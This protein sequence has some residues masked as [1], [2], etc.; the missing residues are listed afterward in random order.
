ML[1]VRKNVST[2]ATDLKEICI[3]EIKE[4]IKVCQIL[5]QQDEEEREDHFKQRKQLMVGLRGK[6]D[7]GT[8]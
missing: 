3:K 1:A 7:H 2:F 8:V 6:T 4:R 5:Q